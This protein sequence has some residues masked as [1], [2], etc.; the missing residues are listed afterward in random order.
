MRA[1]IRQLGTLLAEDRLGEL[2]A[3][4]D[5]DGDALLDLR[6]FFTFVVLLKKEKAQPAPEQSSLLW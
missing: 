5:T 1:A 4:A 6:E 3:A 2:F